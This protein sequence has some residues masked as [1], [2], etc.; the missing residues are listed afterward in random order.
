M[1][2]SDT[3]DW[4]W[5][6]ER[7]CDECGF[8]SAAVDLPDVGAAIRANARAWQVV[9]AGPDP[10]RR[11][12]PE[13]WSVTEY[14]AHVRDVHTVFAERLALMLEVDEPQFEDWD[15]D[16]GAVKGRYDLAT[17]QQVAPALAANA[18][19]VAAG[20]DDVDPA[21]YDRIGHRSNG[22]T[23]TVESLARYHL[24]DVVHPL[25]DVRRELTVA[26]YDARA[27]AYRAA[28]PEPAERVLAALADFAQ[29]V[30]TGAR[31]LEIGSGSGQD[32]LDLWDLTVAYSKVPH[33]YELKTPKSDA[34]MVHIANVF[35]PYF[36]ARE[37]ES[38]EKPAR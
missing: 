15:Q 33:L 37:W 6:L 9:L 4:T 27:T 38:R 8:D 14:A 31:I 26:A 19:D 18:E 10:S 36:E 16:A 24:H 22:S 20:Y 12:D 2:M 13:V 1:T 21:S 11:R 7:A 32:A 3:K 30:G 5:V 25:W 28:R 17:P 35:Q 34:D 23:F 29:R